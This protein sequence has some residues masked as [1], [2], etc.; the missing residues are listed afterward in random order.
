MKWAAQSIVHNTDLLAVWKQSRPTF[1]ASLPKE[2]PESVTTSMNFSV[3]PC[4]NFFEYSCGNWI[5]QAVIPPSQGGTAK[6]WDYAEDAAYDDLRELMQKKYPANSEFRK[7]SDWFDSCMNVTHADL[8]GAEP[9]KPWLAKV[10]AI[11][12]KEDVWDTI[13]LFKLWSIP[14]MISTQVS[15]DEKDPLFYDLFIDSGGLILP[16]ISY[17]DNTTADGRRKL[18]ALT[19]YLQEITQLAGYSEEEAQHA[20]NQTVEIEMM[21]ADL[22]YSEPFVELEDSYHHYNVSQLVDHAPHIPWRKL[23]DGLRKG[24]AGAGGS[25]LEQLD[26]GRKKIVMDSP[27]FYKHISNKFRDAEPGYWKPYLRTHLIYNLSPLLS[28]NFLNATLKLDK[29]LEGMETRPPRWRKCVAAVKHALPGLCDKLYVDKTFGH[30]ARVD[31]ETM[32]EQLR[33]A[34]IRNLEDVTWMDNATKQAALVK[35]NSIDFNIGS[36]ISPP[37]LLDDYPV[38]PNSYFDNSMMAYHRKLIYRL[39]KVDQPVN[40]KEW[41]M[42]AST[43]NAYYDNGVTALFVPAAVLQPPFFSA[44]YNAARNFGGIG[45]IMGHE[46]T[47]GFDDTG[48]KFDAKSRLREWWKKPI[49]Q[50]FQKHSRC[51]AKLY[52]KFEIADETVDGNGTLGENIADM[53]GLKIALRAY[54]HLQEQET[55]SPPKDADQRLFFVSFAQNWCDKERHQSEQEAVLTDE[56]SPNLFRVNGPVSQNKDFARLFQCPVGSPMN[57]D[58][59]CVLWQDIK[60]SEQLVTWNTMHKSAG[61]LDIDRPHR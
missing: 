6:S 5:K 57:P 47:H 52:D 40:R 43:V 1:L 14:T 50:R 23:F 33:G 10:D 54:Q 16:D 20:A 21:M 30:A 51:I 49:V 48:R 35:A 24:C 17:Y 12:T 36:E 44:D 29:Q 22:Q 26:Q 15:A 55:G 39:S 27:Y 3:D 31:A 34:F 9:I 8:L 45:A 4:T 38:N 7:V 28:T 60:P 41:S 19:T 11:Q 59:K 61:M 56:H 37:S 53:G 13:I 42:R 2:F 25:C 18:R 58:N 46:F 32:M